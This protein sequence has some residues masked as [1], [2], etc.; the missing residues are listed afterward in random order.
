MF[1]NNKISVLVILVLLLQ[2]PVLV[3]V[4]KQELYHSLS[5]WLGQEMSFVNRCLPYFRQRLI[6]HLL[7]A[8][9]FCRLCLLKVRVESSSL[10]LLLLRCPGL[11]AL[12]F[13]RLCLLKV[14]ME[15]SSLPSPLLQCAQSTPPFLLHVLFSSLFIFQF[16]FLL[17]FFCGTRSVCP[18]GYAALS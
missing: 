13:F 5:R 10:H 16:L 7:S 1:R 17:F 18:G 3:L 14:Y 12:Y 8:V 9:Y 15:S 6:T 4:F 2:Y 11:S